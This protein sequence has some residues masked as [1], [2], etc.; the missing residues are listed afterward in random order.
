[1]LSH[2]GSEH[3]RCTDMRAEP[4][5]AATMLHFEPIAQGGKLALASE[6]FVQ[7]MDADL[8]GQRHA[9]PAA[10]VRVRGPLALAGRAVATVAVAEE[11]TVH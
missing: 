11:P 5:G 10:D 9:G 3:I 6:D 7:H 8:A 4:G 1:M 2:K